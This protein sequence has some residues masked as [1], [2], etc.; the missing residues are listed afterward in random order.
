MAVEDWG[1][2]ARWFYQKEFGTLWGLYSPN[3]EQ[4]WDFDTFDEAHAAYLDAV[5]CEQTTPFQNYTET[6]C[7]RAREH[8]G[9]HLFRSLRPG[10]ST[11]VMQPK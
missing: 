4:Q 1:S 3:N 9:A 2:E 8:E 7:Y 10:V 11:L 6:R 5:T